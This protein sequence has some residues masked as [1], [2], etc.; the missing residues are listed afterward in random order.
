MSDR[1]IA[2]RRGAVLKALASVVTV[3]GCL[4]AVAYAATPC[5]QVGSDMGRGTPGALAKGLRAGARNEAP[6]QGAGAIPAP[7]VI[8]HPDKTATSTTAR[9]GFTASR[10]NL[11]F[12][13]R[14]DRRGWR[15]CRTPVVFTGL[16]IGTHKF[17]VRALDDR[18]QRSP[19]HRF[20]WTLLEPKAFAIQPRLAGLSPLYPGAPPVALPL[21]ITNPNPVPIFITG[22]QAT[23]TADPQG[24]T[25]AQ[26][27]ALTQS[28]VSS[29]A[30]LKVSAGGSVS[31]P[32]KGVS[33]PAIQLRELPVNQ[34][35]CQN[36]QFPLAFSG[37]ARR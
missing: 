15:T 28:S 5:P 12:Q 27:I 26:N 14:L 22:L 37:Q 34:D 7:K 25:S 11:R 2:R 33:A 29:S 18:G 4:G 21:L 36:A 1:Q 17:S 35:A 23:T 31:L 6:G 10:A 9:F 16:A 30:P 13:C 32:A 3:A 8:Q 20:R 24:C 19:A